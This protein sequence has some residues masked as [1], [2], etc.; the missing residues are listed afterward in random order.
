MRR[1]RSLKFR[2]LAVQ[3]V[4]WTV[5]PL[6]L[7]LI[8]VAFTGVY[9]HEQA[10]RSLVQERDQALA[11]VS[12]AQVREILLQRGSALEVLASRPAFAEA[13]PAAQRAMLTEAGTLNGL[14]AG[15]LAVLD[16]AGAPLAT[17]AQA[18]SWIEAGAPLAALARTVAAEQHLALSPILA[19]QPVAGTFLLG[20][21]LYDPNGAVA[22]V[23]AGPVSPASLRLDALL[24]QAQVGQH[25]AVYLV[26]EVGG[27]LAH[28]P[29]EHARITFAGHSGLDTAQQADCPGSTQ[30][31]SPEG[32]AMALAYAPLELGN[33]WQVIVEEP[34]H[35]VVSPVLRYS[36]LVPLVL[37]LAVV[38][39][40]L[41]LYYGI[42]SLVRPLRALKRQAE[43]VAWGDFDAASSPVGGVE[44][45]ED[46]Q[47]TL[48]QMAGRIQ[49][50]QR[51]MHDYIAAITQGQEEERRRLARE[52]HDDTA[53]SLI[54]L[55][56][57][58][59][60]AQKLLATNPERAAERLAAVRSMIAE[61]LESVRRFSRDLRPI[62][63]EDLGFIPALEML[64][65]EASQRQDVEVDF[66][67][68]GT[69]R[70]LAPDLELAAYR[71][72]QEALNNALQHSGARRVWVE[73]RFEAEC[74]VL[75]LRDDG[76]G[77]DAPDLPDVMVRQGHLGLM[78]IQERALLY[79]GTL[80]IRSTPG[81]GTELTVRLACSAAG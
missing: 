41:T 14:F 28:S 18:P 75:T 61:S 74:L 53:Q 33:G 72:V 31:E 56:Q 76:R 21:P 23:L 58:V 54:A 27:V 34:W 3:I 46:L 71:I 24:S 16:A 67:T 47:R 17:A 81:Q 30:C 26:D 69:V 6:T 80:S 65:R 25:G 57:Q 51:G 70:R 59:E 44:E 7:V 35:E 10:M 42:H 68:A 52:L 11:V 50:Y 38:I 39:A 22:G 20:V 73:V 63:L 55:G 29:S 48:D 19:S 5:L 9:S 13:D 79:G 2:G 49:G 12:A 37:A 15:E 43:Q 77:F 64:A 60:M 45:I 36:Q 40:L 4:L 8:G 78:G 1:L 62:Y 32:E 66:R